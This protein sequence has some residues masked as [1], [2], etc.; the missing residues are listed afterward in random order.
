MIATD[1]EIVKVILLLTGSIEGARANI[2]RF[3]ATFDEFSWLYNT[4]IEQDIQK[5]KK[6]DPGLIEYEAKL[7]YL[8]SVE[9]VI[10]K[11]KPQEQIGAMSLLTQNLCE[12]LKRFASHWKVKYSDNLHT[13]AKYN[14]ET[15]HD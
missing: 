15:I 12:G 1:K 9:D 3:L 5:F 2:N 6:K 8:V 14:L 11:I 10:D 13:I 7:K 4:A